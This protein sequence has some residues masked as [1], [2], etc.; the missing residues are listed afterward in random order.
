MAH[1]SQ[2]P[3]NMSSIGAVCDSLGKT[4][5]TSL[6]GN[7]WATD[8]LRVNSSP[9]KGEFIIFPLFLLEE[10]ALLSMI[11]RADCAWNT[12][13]TWKYNVQNPAYFPP[14]E[15]I[16]LLHTCLSGIWLWSSHIFPYITFYNLENSTIYLNIFNIGWNTIKHKDK[17]NIHGSW[18]W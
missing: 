7:Y 17:P 14:H 8:G 13:R 18:S 6:V 16:P 10:N 2:T 1:L 5:L 9:V 11:A 3:P 4:S 12:V 15:M